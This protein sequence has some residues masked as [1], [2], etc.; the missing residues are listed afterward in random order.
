MQPGRELFT[1]G[2]KNTY[3]IILGFTIANILMG[4]FGALVT[5]RLIHIT[6]IPKSIMG[7]II[8]VLS[9]VGSYAI[10]RNM[11]DVFTMVAFGI[12]GYFMNKADFETA[13][14]VLA[15]V[16]GQTAETGY[17]Q[18]VIM[19]RGDLLGYF[20]GRPICVVLMALIVFSLLLPVI[21]NWRK[22]KKLQLH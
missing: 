17:R 6:R 22:K 20:M 3:A 16:L 19:S 2:A 14:I 10:N 21:N 12:L 13:G 11:F 8:V 9:V 18:A 4:F 1:A 15:L 7:P 5:K